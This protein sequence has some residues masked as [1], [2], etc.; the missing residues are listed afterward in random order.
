MINPNFKK[1]SRQ[2]VLVH[3]EQEREEWLAAGMSEADIFRVQFGEE[4]EKGKGGDYRVWLD[5]RKHTRSDHKYAPG[6]PV[7]YDAVDPN[8]AWI[9]GGRG[10]LDDAEFNIDFETALSKLPTAQRDLAE[11]I[12]FGGLT[13][14]EYARGKQ[15]SKAAVSQT[16]ERIRKN[17]KIFLMKD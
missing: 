11:A 6:T 15:I 10:G 9:N 13:P 4:S 16:L 8:N 2:Q 17:L 12:I 14:A 3:F 1:L 5:E 7:A